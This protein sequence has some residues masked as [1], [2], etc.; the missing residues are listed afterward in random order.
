M[1]KGIS[2]FIQVSPSR[3]YFSIFKKHPMSIP[4]LELLSLFPSFASLCVKHSA[5]SYK[6]PV[7]LLEEV[8]AHDDSYEGYFISCLYYSFM[9]IHI[10]LQ[11]LSNA[12]LYPNW[13]R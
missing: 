3:V 12:F 7:S 9:H 4:S 5:F 1:G 8:L 2:G 13:N 11:G 10:S 6:V